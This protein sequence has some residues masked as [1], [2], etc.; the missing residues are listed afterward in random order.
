MGI[1]GLLP[2][3]KSILDPQH[4]SAYAGKKVAIDAYAWLH[5]AAYTCSQE[6]VL[7]QPTSK[8]L[9]WCVH[10][11]KMLLHYKVIPVLVFDGCRLPEKEKTEKERQDSREKN[12][13]MAMALLQSGQPAAA[14]KMFQKAIDIT[15]DIARTFIHMLQKMNI[16]KERG[17]RQMRGRGDRMMLILNSRLLP[18]PLSPA[19]FLVAPYEADAQMAY[20]AH[21]GYVSCVI[22]EDSDLIV[23]GCPRILYKM[24]KDGHGSEIKLKSMGAN[25]DL[26]FIGWT[27]SQIQQMAIFSG[28]DYLNS[29]N[30]VGI[31]K[32]HSLIK[33]H[34]SY[35]KAIRRLKLDGKI[36][37][38]IEYEKEFELAFLTFQHQRV[39][40]PISKK[41]VHL[42]PL[43]EG[44]ELRFPDSSFLGP[45]MEDEIASGIA[46]GRYNPDTKQPFPASHAVR[47]APPAALQHTQTNNLFAAGFTA[48]PRSQMQP[49][50]AVGTPSH[51]FPVPITAA[52]PSIPS[53]DVLGGFHRKH[54][55]AH[56]HQLPAPTAALNGVTLYD[57]R[58]GIQ[59]PS[60][61]L[62]EKRQKIINAVGGIMEGG[63][64][65]LCGQKSGA[66]TEPLTSVAT[67]RWFLSY[68]L[69]CQI[70][71]NYQLT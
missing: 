54:S 70:P 8:W 68:F 44:F 38:P 9:E 23:F 34:G 18:F 33:T 39:Y 25:Q 62:D 36:S 67:H 19:E 26:S 66:L 60:Q 28:C 5:R 63:D 45:R 15:P 7:G 16:G 49:P 64:M 41:L 13:T 21:S 12:R 10:R 37:V 58:H 53:A 57:A 56:H 20:L 30:G 55:T 11:C 17:Q 6:L 47:L 69:L 71:P 31:K 27:Q 42:T 3:L 43:P 59:A 51:H 32:A 48:T 46:E 50:A 1:Q 29:L 2:M 40:D 24:D 14:Y 52:P 61:P 4:I 35:E 22:T 65:Q